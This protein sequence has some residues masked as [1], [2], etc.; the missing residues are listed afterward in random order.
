MP[1]SSLPH[2]HVVCPKIQSHLIFFHFV[3]LVLCTSCRKRHYQI[4]Q[5]KQF[6]SIEPV[7]I[8][9]FSVFTFPFQLMLEFNRIARPLFFFFW[10][11]GG[12]EGGGRISKTIRC[13]N[14]KLLP[15]NITDLK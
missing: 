8:L 7:S 13:L 5:E 11:G 4:R 6:A 12:G 3:V 9:T 10:G 15:F 1:L 14:I 2:H